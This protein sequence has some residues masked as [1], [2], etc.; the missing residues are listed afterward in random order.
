MKIVYFVDGL[1]RG[2]IEIVVSHLSNNIAKIGNQ[3]H[4]ICLYQDKKELEH[5]LKDVQIHYL[6]FKSGKSNYI[7]YL[8]SLPTLIGLLKKIH[9]DIIHAHNASFSYFYLSIA[10]LLS[11]IRCVNIRSLH[12]CGF[13]LE[14]KTLRD[15][16]RFFLDKLASKLLNAKIISVGPAVETVAKQ[17]YPRNQHY[18]ITNGIDTK[19][20]FSKKD[21]L[22]SSL[23]LNDSQKV[24]IYVAR[25][26]NGKNHE[27]LINAWEIVTQYENTSLLILVGDGPLLKNIQDIV[28][29]KQ[30]QNKVLFTGS[31]SNV[32]DFLSIADLGVFPSESEGLGLGLIEMMSIGLP[33]I[34]SRIPAFKHIINDKDNGVLYETNNYKELAY[35]ILDLLNDDEQK[36]KLG[37]NAKSFIHKHYSIENMITQ[38]SFLYNKL[39]NTHLK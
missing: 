13:F 8:H 21:I 6:P 20:K 32:E 2:G 15:K 7:E 33:V 1:N 29:A 19:N 12:F 28:L 22:K 11:N 24:V 5:E 4:L 25:I 38:H 17:L 9:P 36:R 35:K 27:T 3:V 26:C 16:V 31:I 37:E 34:A 14:R 39:Y 18:T 23:G 30:I 10:V